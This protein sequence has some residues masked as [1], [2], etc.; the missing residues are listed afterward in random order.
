MGTRVN[1]YFRSQDVEPSPV[2]AVTSSFGDS[3]EVP[4][5]DDAGRA[6]AL[7]G[8]IETL[9]FRVDDLSS[10]S[11]AIAR[12][13]ADADGDEVLLPDT[14]VELSYGITTSDSGTG[15]V[16]YGVPLS[17]PSTVTS[18]YVFVKLDPAVTGNLAHVTLNWSE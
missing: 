14:E 10:S 4:L 13:C 17:L 18:L 16:Y 8:R 15:V 3:V 1:H 7:R 5:V 6:F 2:V 12:V 9:N 11:L